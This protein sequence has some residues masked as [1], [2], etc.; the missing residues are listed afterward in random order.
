V[1]IRKVFEAGDFGPALTPE[2]R[3]AEEQL[4]AESAKQQG[5]A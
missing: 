3:E 2:L 5:H 4:R 1:E